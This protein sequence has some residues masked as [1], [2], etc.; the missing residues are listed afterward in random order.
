[1]ALKIA[2]Q[3][4]RAATITGILAKTKYI[5]AMDLVTAEQTRSFLEATWEKFDAENEWIYQSFRESALELPYFKEGRYEATMHS[6]FASL[7]LLNRHISALAPQASQARVQEQVR[8]RSSLPIIDLPKFSG[9]FT[10]WRPFE[11]LFSSLVKNN[12]DISQVEKMHYLRSSL[13]G[14]AAKVITNLKLSA[15]S[16]E[17][18]WKRLVARFDNKRLLVLAQV[19]R[20]LDLPPVKTRTSH[21]LHR[22]VNIVESSLSAI[23]ALGCPVEHW[24]PIVLQRASSALDA[25]TR[26]DWEHHLGASTEIP[27]YQRLLSFISAVARDLEQIEGHKTHEKQM[28]SRT[29]HEHKA[30]PT[31]SYAKVLNL[32][33]QSS[34]RPIP[35][36]QTSQQPAPSQQTS[37]QPANPQPS[38]QQAA[39]PQT[40]QGQSLPFIQDLSNNC[41]YCRRQHY[42]AFCPQFASLSRKNRGGT[43][44]DSAGARGG[45]TSVESSTTRSS[46]KN[47]APA[48]PSHP[49]SIPIQ[50]VGSSSPGAT[51]GQVSLILQST[52]SSSQVNLKALILPKITS[53]VPSSVISEQD[54]PHLRPLRLADPVFLTPNPI[55]ILI[56]ADN[57]RRVI[58]Q[59]YC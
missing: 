36:Q 26:E 20:L 54:W 16:F 39:T 47:T 56:G 58:I 48:Q 43:M 24:G 7:S 22:I 3:D 8:S 12:P 4:Q 25:R 28:S 2:L 15:E 21:G 18:A 33:P 41:C 35:K 10:D 34:P 30:S 44:F 13:E 49:G 46:T 31:R 59:G 37:P 19:E 52:Y 45:A 29:S 27:P 14:E 57:L 1:M 17:I 40:S 6:Y 50:D 38:Q 51:Q 9:S 55:D 11:D 23:E 32:G 53:Q 42:L 5:S